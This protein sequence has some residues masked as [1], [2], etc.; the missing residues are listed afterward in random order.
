MRF[1]WPASHHADQPLRLAL[2]D[3][4]IDHLHAELHPPTRQDGDDDDTPW[5]DNPTEVIRT[6]DRLTR[7]RDDALTGDSKAQEQHSPLLRT[8]QDV[9]QRLDLTPDDLESDDE[10]NEEYC[11]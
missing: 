5:D 4:L 3:R 7:W 9:A 2:C 8:R 1:Q 6:L 11:E 10:M